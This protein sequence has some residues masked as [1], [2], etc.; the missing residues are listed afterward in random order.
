MLDPRSQIAGILVVLAAAWLVWTRPSPM[1]WGFFLY[2]NWFN[3]GQ[4]HG[5]YALL[6]P[7]PV[8]FLATD[9][10]MVLAQDEFTVEGGHGWYPF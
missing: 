4:V 9:I 7:R 10:A 2:V 3:P 1:S 6:E 8:L 5:F